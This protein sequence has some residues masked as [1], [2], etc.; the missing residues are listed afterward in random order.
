MISV[1]S[2]DLSI[3]ILLGQWRG[4][5]RISQFNMELSQHEIGLSSLKTQSISDLPL[6][7]EYLPTGFRS[8]AGWQTFSVMSQIVNILS[9]QVI[10]SLCNYS[11]LCRRGQSQFINK[12]PGCILI[13]LCVWT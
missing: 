4:R 13:K 5:L 11:L 3:L 10:Q 8:V 2:K 12:G 6:F 1:S 7:L 9:L